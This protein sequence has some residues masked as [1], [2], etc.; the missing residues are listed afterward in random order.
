MWLLLL[1]LLIISCQVPLGSSF[2]ASERH[3]SSLLKKFPLHSLAMS[4]G[5]EQPKQGDDVT[6]T[7]IE[8]AGTSTSNNKR[9]AVSEPTTNGE[10]RLDDD[11]NSKRLKI[12]SQKEEENDQKKVESSVSEPS[13][14][15]GTFS[16]KATDRK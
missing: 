1:L 13:E 11:S 2:L 5:D 3:Y 8:P 15:D 7:T 12:N 14:K 9:E 10:E 16:E 4:D 6:R